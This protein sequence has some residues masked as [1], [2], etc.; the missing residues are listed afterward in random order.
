MLD[1]KTYMYIL[2]IY[3]SINK[4]WTFTIPYWSQ[5]LFHPKHSL[6]WIVN[7]T[8]NFTQFEY[9]IPSRVALDRPFLLTATG[10]LPQIKIYLMFDLIFN[11]HCSLWEPNHLQGMILPGKFMCVPHHH[12]RFPCHHFLGCETEASSRSSRMWQTGLL[13]MALWWLSG[14]LFLIWTYDKL[15]LFV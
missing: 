10:N 5:M 2:L 3:K 15:L 4:K 11:F 12:H 1:V 6:K 13:K 14:H 9:Y 8:S 7:S